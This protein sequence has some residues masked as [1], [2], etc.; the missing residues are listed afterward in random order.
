MR[1]YFNASLCALLLISSTAAQSDTAAV[2][3]VPAIIPVPSVP[4]ATS[5]N[6]QQADWVFSGMV[7][8]ESGD[9]YHYY[10]E[11]QRKY[12]V[13]HAVATLV[14][15]ENKNVVLYEES[16]A[17]IEKPDATHWQVG[18]IFLHFNPI[19]DSWV[20][21]VE[22]QH[23]LGFNFKV[24]MLGQSDL[25]LSKQQDLRTGVELLVSQT[26]RLNGHLQIGE[27]KKEL[28]VTAPKSW[29]KQI[30]AAESQVLNYP[31]SGVL[32]EFD[33]G[34]V[35]YMVDPEN[36]K[37]LKRSSI[38][39]LRD[40]KGAA[41][42]VS[43]FAEVSEKEGNWLI[44]MGSTGKKFSLQDMLIKNSETHQIIAGLTEDAAG[45]CTISR[46]RAV[47]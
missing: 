19:T 14:S 28:F 37:A 35:F 47:S 7:T 11:I 18:R 36:S 3:A 5:L 16:N 42:S 4:K 41:V 27:D 45:F 24:E 21:G 8:D 31:L 10:F 17:I 46:S 22:N 40:I 23:N 38:V 12:Q 26:G 2:E 33:D 44:D 20:F 9:R 6:S 25:A 29:F 15:G 39:G 32:C 13:F 30:W 43:Q 34:S 1:S